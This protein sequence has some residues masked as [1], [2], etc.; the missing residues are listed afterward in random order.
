MTRCTPIRAVYIH[1]PGRSSRTTLQQAVSLD[2]SCR[3]SGRKSLWSRYSGTIT[4][5][6]L[7]GISP[8]RTMAVTARQESAHT[9]EGLRLGTACWVPAGHEISPLDPMSRSGL[10]APRSQGSINAFAPGTVVAREA[11][12]PDRRCWKQDGASKGCVVYR[13]TSLTLLGASSVSAVRPLPWPDRLHCQSR[14]AIIETMA[15]RTCP[16]GRRYGL[17]ESERWSDEHRHQQ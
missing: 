17:I 1:G 13:M 10:Y 16:T 5:E 15:L 9:Q 14:F 11:G 2:H 4:R 7:D 6:W 8:V 3:I 12:V